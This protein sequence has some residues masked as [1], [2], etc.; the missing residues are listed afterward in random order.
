M[1]E[2]GRKITSKIDC[3]M[4]FNK[5]SVVHSDICMT[6]LIYN[7]ANKSWL[8][9]RSKT[10]TPRGGVPEAKAK[11]AVVKLEAQPKATSSDQSPEAVTQQIT[12]L[13]SAITNQNVNNNGQI[14][15]NHNNGVENLLNLKDQKRIGRT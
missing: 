10:E 12:Y 9:E 5:I 7:A 6:N 2:E 15:P 1:A 8:L 14:G 4:G 11:S 3:F 13:M